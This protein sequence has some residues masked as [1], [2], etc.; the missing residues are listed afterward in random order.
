MAAVNLVIYRV[1]G[2]NLGIRAENLPEYLQIVIYHSPKISHESYVA[3]SKKTA[4][5][6]DGR[7]QIF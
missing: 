4:K 3:L 2:R 1:W 7:Q 5:I 6:Q